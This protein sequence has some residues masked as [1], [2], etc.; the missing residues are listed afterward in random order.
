MTD[1]Y[2][3]PV[4]N[5]DGVDPMAWLF[6]NTPGAPKDT[7]EVANARC[8]HL[9]ALGVNLT[10]EVTEPSTLKYDALG[11]TGAP[12]EHGRWI[13]V[14]QPR[15]E[16]TVTAPSTDITAMSEAERAELRAALDLADIATQAGGGTNG[17]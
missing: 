17:R 2:P 7:L 8:A 14:D 6:F 15:V 4:D 16:V 5:Q 10:P 11:G 13:P 12:W 3:Y 9:R 1:I